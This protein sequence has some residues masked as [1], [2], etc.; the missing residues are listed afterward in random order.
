MEATVRRLILG[1]LFCHCPRKEDG[2]TVKLERTRAG[3]EPRRM[4]PKVVPSTCRF[5]FLRIR[6]W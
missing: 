4:V 1:L 6:F 2:A 5:S 3:L